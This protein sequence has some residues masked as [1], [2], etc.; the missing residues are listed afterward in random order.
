MCDLVGDNFVEGCSILNFFVPYNETP[1]D[2]FSACLSLHLLPCR[3]FVCCCHGCLT[4]FSFGCYLQ[5]V[6]VWPNMDDLV[7]PTMDSGLPMNDV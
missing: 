2:F 4:L 3:Y 6:F 5:K 1:A 7:I